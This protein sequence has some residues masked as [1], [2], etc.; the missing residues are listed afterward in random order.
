MGYS[1]DHPGQM[2]GERKLGK[3]VTSIDQLKQLTMNS[4]LENHLTDSSNLKEGLMYQYPL[5]DIP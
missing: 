5:R 1:S 2:E 4:R 3:I